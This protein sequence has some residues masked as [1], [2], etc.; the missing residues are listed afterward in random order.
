MG[1]KVSKKP[2]CALRAAALRTNRRVLWIAV[3]SRWRARPKRVPLPLSLCC[4]LPPPPRRLEINEVDRAVLTLKSQA[5]KLQQQRGRVRGLGHRCRR[6]RPSPCVAARDP[7]RPQFCCLSGLLAA[8]RPRHAAHCLQI[9]GNIDREMAVARELV[10]QG[11]KERALL[12]LKRRKLQEGQAAKLDAWLLNVE[13]MV[14][15][16]GWVRLGCCRGMPVAGGGMPSSNW[17]NAK[18][19]SG[20]NLHAHP[21]AAAAYPPVPPPPA[22]TPL[23]PPSQPSE[24]SC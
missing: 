13:E 5:R 7:V 22:A 17:A 4:R 19:E 8:S 9:Q 21:F 1:Q 18:F 3:P 2:K 10:G 20:S 16:S 24:R 15:A 23:L 6:L 11:R 12:A 14:G